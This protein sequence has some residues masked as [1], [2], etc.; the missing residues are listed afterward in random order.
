MNQ[1]LLKDFLYKEV[2]TSHAN[3]PLNWLGLNATPNSEN[4]QN[5]EIIENGNNI[6]IHWIGDRVL[7]SKD[8]LSQ[9]WIDVTN[10]TSPHTIDIENNPSQFFR[11]GE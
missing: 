3:N 1:I 6:Q 11:F 5:L 7:Q 2:V 8:D 10:M 4:V 9:P